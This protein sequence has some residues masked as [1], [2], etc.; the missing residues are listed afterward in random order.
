MFQPCPL[1]LLAARR[2]PQIKPPHDA[3]ETLAQSLGAHFLILFGWLAALAPRRISRSTGVDGKDPKNLMY[4]F[5]IGGL[6]TLAATAQT[7]DL[8][9]QQDPWFP[10]S[11]KVAR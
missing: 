2:F 10:F 9:L 6:Q 7:G 11:V 8:A 3:Q 1:I 4:D 5:W